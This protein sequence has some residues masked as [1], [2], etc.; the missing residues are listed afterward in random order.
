MKSCE[1]NQSLM[2]EGNTSDKISAYHIVVMWPKSGCTRTFSFRSPRSYA[3]V[4][5]TTG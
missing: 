4:D 2:E 3:A 1:H 5:K